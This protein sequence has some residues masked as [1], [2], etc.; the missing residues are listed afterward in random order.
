MSRTVGVVVLAA[1]MIFV[2]ATA[3]VRSDAAAGLIA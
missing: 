2:F 1:L 3:S